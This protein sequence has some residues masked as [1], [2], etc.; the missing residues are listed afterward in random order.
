MTLNITDDQITSETTAHTARF[1]PDAA[2]DGQ[3]AWTVTWLRGRLL[4]FNQ[5]ITAMTIAETVGA[6]GGHVSWTEP[7]SIR[8]WALINAMAQELH[9]TGSFAAAEAADPQGPAIAGPDTSP[10]GTALRTVAGERCP[11][12]CVTDHEVVSAA[13]EAPYGYTQVHRS[14]ALPPADGDYTDYVAARAFVVQRP[15]SLPVVGLGA[16]GGQLTMEFSAEHAWQLAAILRAGG[17]RP[18][19]AD[20]LA[21]AADLVAVLV[22]RA[23]R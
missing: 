22:L 12:W 9:V 21:A 20:G 7:E 1:G 14:Q 11:S 17:L 10:A 15:Q 19:V 18:P 13:A 3:G 5:A 8:W 4:T 23:T 6:A 2:A 16:L